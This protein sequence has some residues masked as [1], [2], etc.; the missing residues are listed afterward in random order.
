M[1]SCSTCTPRVWGIEL[2][3]GELGDFYLAGELSF[4]S[5]PD[6]GSNE[7]TGQVLWPGIFAT[8]RT[9]LLPYYR[10]AW[11]QRAPTVA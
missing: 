8:A 10:S 9:E 1:A 6:E 4:P 2:L 11:R 3:P 7:L 5:L